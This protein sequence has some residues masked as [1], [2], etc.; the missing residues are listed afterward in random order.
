[1]YLY[2]IPVFVDRGRIMLKWTKKIRDW[3]RKGKEDSEMILDIPWDVKVEENEKFDRIKASHPRFPFPVLIHVS[4][5][6]VQL[7]IDP[8]I[9]T[10]TMDVT[11]RMRLY[12]RMLTLNLEFNLVKTALIGEDRGIILASDLD[13]KSLNHDEFDDALTFLIASTVRIVELLGLSENLNKMI[14]DMHRALVADMY[15]AGKT[16]AEILSFLTKRI[17]LEEDYSK[18]FLDAIMKEVDGVEETSTEQTEQDEEAVNRY[19]Q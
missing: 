7:H 18:E 12:R 3:L 17:G 19:I 16:E 15:K 5:Q 13:L 11:E 2:H 6:F 14:F 1:M 4:E 8:N 10:D 9:P